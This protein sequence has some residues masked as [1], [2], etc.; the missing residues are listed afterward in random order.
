MLF[1]IDDDY[2]FAVVKG[3]KGTEKSLVIPYEADGY[4]VTEIGDWAFGRFFGANPLTFVS[5]PES[6][7]DIGHFAFHNCNSLTNI[8]FP[9]G[10]M[11][12]GVSAFSGCYALEAVTI[13]PGVTVIEE[14]TFSGCRSL[15][16]LNLH[17][18]ITKI[19]KGAFEGCRMLSSV[20]LPPELTR[21]EYESFRDCRSLSHITIHEGI[22]YVGNYAFSGCRSLAHVTLPDS[23]SFIGNR[24]AFPLTTV[25]RAAYGSYAEHF[26]RKYYYTFEPV[27]PD[28]YIT[29]PLSKHDSLS[30]VLK[31]I[32]D[33]QGVEAFKNLRIFR[34]L[35]SDFLPGGGR[36]AGL[37]N[38]LYAA[39]DELRIYDV[40]EQAKKNEDSIAVSRLAFS[41]MEMGYQENLAKETVACFE[42]LVN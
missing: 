20:V 12:I 17:K 38:I 36:N 23:V 26:A 3:Y 31:K 42:E 41:L 14:R 6:V 30:D 5:I 32:M 9:D 10:L 7:T 25:I 37:R 4:P 19:G 8:F 28:A 35:V 29:E 1:E 18:G 15:T 34:G 33:I 24:D 13:P 16:Q 22:E 2:G 11:S 40:L 21:I 27:Y 39:M